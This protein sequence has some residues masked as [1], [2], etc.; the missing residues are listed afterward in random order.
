MWAV[1]WF[2]MLLY[3]L[4]DETVI[5][6]CGFWVMV[7]GGM[8]RMSCFATHVMHWQDNLCCRAHTIL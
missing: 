6:F 1:A 5:A 8:A 4:D 7:N 3:L 2:V